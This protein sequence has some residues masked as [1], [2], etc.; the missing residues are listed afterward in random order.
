MARRRSAA[1]IGVTGLGQR[2]ELAAGVFINTF[3]RGCTPGFIYTEDGIVLVDTPLIPTQAMDW[4][5]QIEEE[6]PD[7]PF[8]W[9][10]NTDHHRGHALGNQYFL[11]VRVLAHERAYKEMSGY[12]ENFKERVRNSFKREPEIQA[13]LNNII[14]VPPDVTFTQRADLLEGIIHLF[15]GLGVGQRGRCACLLGD[16]HWRRGRLGCFGIRQQPRTEQD[17]EG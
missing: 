15:L 2:E 13:Q 14:I 8:L 4:R 12:T 7:T 17:C 3:Y 10:I 5:A 1:R 11:P 16:I 6:Y 9:L